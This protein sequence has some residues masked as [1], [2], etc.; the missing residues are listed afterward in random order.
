[1]DKNICNI[2]NQL[3]IINLIQE[4]LLKIFNKNMSGLQAYK[5]S[6]SIN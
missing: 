6:K 3:R 1:M 2:C 4:K 5:M